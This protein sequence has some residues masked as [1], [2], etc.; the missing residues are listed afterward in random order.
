[1]EDLTL[2]EYGLTSNRKSAH[3]FLIAG[4][5]LLH[6]QLLSGL[7]AALLHRY[8]IDAGRQADGSMT[9]DGGLVAELA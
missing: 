1:M 7:N 4:K 6:Q 2:N 8:G 5:I 9:L 3:F